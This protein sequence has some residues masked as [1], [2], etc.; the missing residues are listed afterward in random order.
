MV[1]MAPASLVPESDPIVAANPSLYRV[2]KPIH[3]R[4]LAE[5]LL[6]ASHRAIETAEEPQSVEAP[7]PEAGTGA[8]VLVADDNAINRKLIDKIL[9]KLG[10]NPMVVS[11]GI[12]CVDALRDGEFDVVLMDVQMPEMDGLTAT[13]KIRESGNEIPIIALTANAMPEDRKLCIDAGMTDYLCKPIR[14]E[15]LSETIE[16]FS[17]VGA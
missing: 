3:G 7:E 4:D 13:R 9:V 10:Y 16:R 14:A 8:R 11:N 6:K 15:A 12:E 1:L 5:V 17:R 2:T